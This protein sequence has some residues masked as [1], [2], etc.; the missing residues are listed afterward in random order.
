MSKLDRY[1]TFLAVIEENS[2]LGASKRLGISNAA[3][4]KQISKLE[5]EIGVQLLTRSTRRLELTDA[6]RLFY[7]QVNKFV[8]E[9]QELE[10]L[11]S[12]MRIEPSGRLC[13]GGARYFIEKYVVKHLKEFNT[14]YPKVY[15]DIKMH[16]R[17]VDLQNE[18]IDVNL[19]HSIVG[20][21]DDIHKKIA[22]TRYALCASPDY[23]AQFGYPKEPQNLF[24]HRYITHSMRSEDILKFDGQCHIRLQPFIKV[25]DSLIMKQC[26]LE[27]IGIIKV[28]SYAVE[29]E[30]ASG[31][32]IELL[33]NYDTS[34]QPIYL[35]YQPT[36][37][38]QPKI[39]HF[40]DFLLMKMKG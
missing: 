39:R 21:P 4:S 14:L 3:V 16:E 13:L 9:I 35:C 12:E 23:L 2:F 17:I 32:L 7:K 8:G 15:V 1:A 19:G 38:L 10:A 34:V 29:E 26:A 25:N 30:L 33:K 27:G 6:G 22:E 11:F 36:R 20:G 31:K 18:G 28:H 37:Y 40:I 24:E 5:M